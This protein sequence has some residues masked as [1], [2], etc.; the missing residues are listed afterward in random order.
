MGVLP[1]GL[2]GGLGLTALSQPD[3]TAQI[4]QEALRLFG[5]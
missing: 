3:A 5:L 1:L 2:I 4:W